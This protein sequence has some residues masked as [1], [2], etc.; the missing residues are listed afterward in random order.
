[1]EKEEHHSK[2]FGFRTNKTLRRSA[3]DGEKKAYKTEALQE[4]QD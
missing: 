3:P 2:K 4:V 1:M